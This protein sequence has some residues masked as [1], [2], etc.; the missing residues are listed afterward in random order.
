MRASRSATRQTSQQSSLTA[1]VSCAV[2]LTLAQ[3]DRNSSVVL[4]LSYNCYVPWHF[5][6][7]TIRPFGGVFYPHTPVKDQDTAGC[8]P[9]SRVHHVSTAL[10]TL[11]FGHLILRKISKFVAARCEILRL[12]CTKFNFGPKPRWGSLQRSPRH[13]SWI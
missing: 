4:I 6:Y 5:I 3:I 8:T 7:C 11:K 2:A 9:P 12:K 10:S 1:A 13:P